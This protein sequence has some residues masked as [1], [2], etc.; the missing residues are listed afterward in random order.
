[1][2]ANIRKHFSDH[3]GTRWWKKT[4]EAL[5]QIASNY[6]LLW[7]NHKHR[8]STKVSTAQR[9]RSTLKQ[10]ENGGG[11]I[12]VTQWICTS[13]PVLLLFTT[14]I[15]LRNRQCRERSSNFCSQIVRAH[16]TTVDNLFTKR[17]QSQTIWQETAV[18]Q[19]VLTNWSSFFADTRKVSEKCCCLN[20]KDG[21]G[22]K[23]LEP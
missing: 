5:K 2:I 4:N 15:Y 16:K 11:L 8:E 6:L 13:T 14:F 18:H 19:S 20:R 7:N 12:I 10:H 1:M 21:G 9:T 22:K 17:G 3:R 23:A